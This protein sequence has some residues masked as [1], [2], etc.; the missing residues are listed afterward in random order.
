MYL[1]GGIYRGKRIITAETIKLFMQR[2]S[3][4]ADTTRALGWDTPASESFPGKLA[5]PHAI[6]HTGFTGTSI[7]VDPERDAFIILLSNRVYPT[8][9]NNLIFKA[10]PDIHTAILTILD[11]KV[12]P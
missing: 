6:I 12:E 9:N 4:P 3:V 2:Q 11:Q 1:N 8:R 5:S 10:R 7:Y